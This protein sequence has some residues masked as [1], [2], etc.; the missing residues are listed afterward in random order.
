[1]KRRIAL[2]VALVAAVTI[3]A[4]AGSAQSWPLDAFIDDDNSVHESAIDVIANLGITSGCNPPDFD[5]FCP[6]D[7]VTR[8]QMAAFLRR[9]IGLPT[10]STDAFTDDNSSVFE[11]DIN[12]IAAAGITTGCNPAG[13]EFC[14]GGTVTRGQMAAFLRRAAGV[15]SSA[16]DFFTDDDSSIFEAD[17]NAIAA[18]G[19]TTGCDA[20]DSEFCPSEE[21]T[22][23][24][25]ATFLVRA[26]DLVAGPP[27]PA[28]D[29]VLAFTGIC[30]DDQLV[31]EDEIYFPA[32]TPWQFEEGWFYVLPFEP[33]DQEDFES[34][35]TSF[36]VWLDG[37]S[38]PMSPQ[39]T[40]T[41]GGESIRRF[42]GT[43][44]RLQPGTYSLVGE[45]WWAGEPLYRTELTVYVP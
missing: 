9:S 22:R 38:I 37:A 45:W 13:T 7:S 5:E 40:E 6:G 12:A 30:D 25:M 21:V 42:T 35:G 10:S 17:I 23:A 41:V 15:P 2:M 1:M 27:E 36:R 4:P 8:G 14:P 33:G 29:F 11:A 28:L 24:Q 19:I 43:L 16:T 3:A 31:C 34:V 20:A 39:A 32:D 26:F 44:P 18:A